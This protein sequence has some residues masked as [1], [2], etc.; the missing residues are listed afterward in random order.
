MI[1]ETS[2]LILRPWKI[3]DA[4]CRSVCSSMHF[5][6]VDHIEWRMTFREKINEDTVI[7]LL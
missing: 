1:F 4:G 6:P 5:E 7:K 3:E 2:R